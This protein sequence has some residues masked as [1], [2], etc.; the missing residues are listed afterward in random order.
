VRISIDL[1][2]RFTVRVD[3]QEI[4]A[5][6]WRR[7]RAAALVKLLALAPQ[8][9]LHREQVMDAFWPDLDVKLAAANFRK[10]IH[11]ARK[12]LG[13]HELITVGN[14]IVALSDRVD[15]DID[16]EQF[17]AAALTAVRTT[18]TTE[19]AAAADLYRGP[20]LPD[21]RYVEWLDA[22]RDRLQ[23]LYVNVLRTGRLWRQLIALD[24]TDEEAQCALMQAALDTGNRGEAIRL[25]DQLRERLRIELGVGPSAAAIDIY[26]R[27]LALSGVEPATASER[28]RASLAWGLVHLQSGEF[29]KASEIARE[30]RDQALGAGLAREVGE[31]SAVLG[32][33]AKMQDRWRDLFRN[34][35][36]DWVRTRPS[37]VP[38]VFDGHL[39]LAEFCLC[40]ASGPAEA[41]ELAREL[42][43]VA[44]NAKSGAGRGL[45]C[46][47]LGEV[48]IFAGE[49]DEAEQLLTEAEKL[50]LEANAISGR[51]LA[52]ERLAEV[53]LQRGQKWRASRL[54]RR[55][56]ADADQ[57]WLSPH[58][59]MR[60]QALEVRSATTREKTA[61]A[62]LEGDRLLTPGSCQPCS[63]AF[64]TASA[65]ALAEAGELEQVDRRLNDAERIAGMWH[66]GPW[67]AALWEAR[68][69][70]RQAQKNG[71]RAVAAFAE[72][73]ARYEEL[74]RPLDQARCLSRMATAMPAARLADA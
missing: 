29:D 73:A 62:I 53:A 12:A 57:S 25:F 5:N 16:V 43:D 44:D 36:I 32:I 4:S 42:L 60:M 10:A 52:L 70:Q 63:M 66:G 3:G 46:L 13:I 9:R 51:V 8:H 50:L 23:Q 1:L 40:S 41:A 6:E 38:A 48:A 71:V 15:L 11:F 19:C 17:E 59:V 61:G 35:I 21:D 49:L 30:T 31:A 14:E 37:F 2:G 58:L 72:A 28:I 65:I 56:L 27:A 33:T 68:G 18:D 47:I 7:D 74:G 67:A 34:E 55:G 69:V 54:I 26:E 64:R 39:C 20:L 45:A 22:P 24:P